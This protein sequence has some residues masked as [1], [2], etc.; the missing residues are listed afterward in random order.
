MKSFFCFCFFLSCCSLAFSLVETNQQLLQESLKQRLA[1]AGSIESNVKLQQTLEKKTCPGPY[2]VTTYGTYA[3]YANQC[4]C[5]AA[6][7]LCQAVSSTGS[8]T[9]FCNCGDGLVCDPNSNEC[10]PSTFDIFIGALSCRQNS[11]AASV[12]LSASQSTINFS[13]ALQPKELVFCSFQMAVN[14][15][16]GY[17][18]KLQEIELVGVG[19]VQQIGIAVTPTSDAGYFS[20][21]GEINTFLQNE[22]SPV[23]SPCFPELIGLSFTFATS[24]SIDAI[25]L[26]FSW[27]TC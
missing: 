4:T 24:A 13:P 20:A 9:K 7:D 18:Y 19:S 14:G 17:Q 23:T 21:N 3:N 26:K 10:A 2:N 22:A 6:G 16:A 12:S 11:N 15:P 5:S 1:V 25:K 8:T 27:S